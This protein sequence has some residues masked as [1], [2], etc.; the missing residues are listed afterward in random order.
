MALA[1]I[2]SHAWAEASRGGQTPNLIIWSESGEA[3][4]PCKW[5]PGAHGFDVAKIRKLPTPVPGRRNE[6]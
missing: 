2:G 3:A 1:L 5:N 6:G 4:L